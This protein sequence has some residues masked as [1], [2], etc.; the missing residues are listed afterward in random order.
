MLLLQHKLQNTRQWEQ[1]VL[2]LYHSQYLSDRVCHWNDVF[3]FQLVGYISFVSSN[4]IVYTN[5]WILFYSH[6][7]WNDL[8]TYRFLVLCQFYKRRFKWPC[9]KWLCKHWYFIYLDKAGLTHPIPSSIS[10]FRI[11]YNNNITSYNYYTS[12]LK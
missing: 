1:N 6:S 2:V 3:A 4:L 12:Y 8:S 7:N 10:Y 9:T 11:K 5:L